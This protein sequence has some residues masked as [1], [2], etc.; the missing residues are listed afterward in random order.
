[1]PTSFGLSHSTCSLPPSAWTTGSAERIGQRQQLVVG[2]GASRA[3]EH[4]HR[5]CLVQKCREPIEF[6][7][8]REYPC[9]ANLRRIGVGIVLHWTHGDVARQHDDGHASRK[10][11][12][13]HRTL[14]HLRHL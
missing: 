11:G 7:I 3:A 8:R 9:R 5:V 6:G 1:M 14:E 13:S 4:R 10:Q 2:S 12:R